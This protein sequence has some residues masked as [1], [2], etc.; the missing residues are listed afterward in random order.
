MHN[1]VCC[2]EKKLTRDEYYELEKTIE[3]ET[4]RY[5]L[6]S[7]EITRAIQGYAR[8]G[9][10]KYVKN[11]LTANF[12][13]YLT[14]FLI[15][16]S[17]SLQQISGTSTS[18]S[19]NEFLSI[20][21][22]LYKNEPI[23]CSFSSQLMSG[24][25]RIAVSVGFRPGSDFREI[26][27]TSVPT[28]NYQQVRTTIIS[29]LIVVQCLSVVGGPGTPFTS[30][31]EFKKP[32]TNL[33][34][35]AIGERNI[36]TFTYYPDIYG[37][38]FIPRT[39]TPHTVS[40]SEIVVGVSESEYDEDTPYFNQPIVLSTA[41]QAYPSYSQPSY[42]YAVAAVSPSSPF[43]IRSFGLCQQVYDSGGTGRRVT[44]IKKNMPEP[45]EVSASKPFLVSIRVFGL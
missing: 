40:A 41:S 7:L 27:I 23:Q 8:A 3:V 36:G 42:Y 1:L 34:P 10:E 32:W 44:W 15:R 21:Y 33:L 18:V 28:I 22:H 5:K 30:Y 43:S 19:A 16:S 26:A 12:F 11:V 25:T 24:E 29:Y 31:I 2:P 20:T 6:L 14:G 13:A 37:N 38:L 4:L 9:N 45:R 39:S 17:V 35:K